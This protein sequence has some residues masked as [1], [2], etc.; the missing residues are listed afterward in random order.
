MS[1]FFSLL[2]TSHV[3]R[4]LPLA[5]RRSVF[6]PDDDETVF[7]PPPLLGEC[8][9]LACPS[10][11]SSPSPTL[12]EHR[13]RSKRLTLTTA[14]L[15]SPVARAATGRTASERDALFLALPESPAREGSAGAA[16]TPP[17]LA[18][19]DEEDTE[20]SAERESMVAEAIVGARE[21]WERRGKES[22][23]VDGRFQE[24]SGSEK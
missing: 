12:S 17:R 14:G 23:G 24:K 20:E 7:L 13:E 2:K 21:G 6:S 16:A 15:L 8:A 18:A 5:C 3:V 1:V 4:R 10:G 9:A 19:E 22:G 11:P